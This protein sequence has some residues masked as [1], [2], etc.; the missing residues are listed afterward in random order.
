MTSSKGGSGF[1]DTELH[2]IPSFTIDSSVIL[3][4]DSIAS[5]F[6]LWC[7]HSS[8]CS[9]QLRD[10]FN[11]R[12]PSYK[13]VQMREGWSQKSIRF[14][15]V[16]H[17]TQQVSEAAQ[18]YSSHKLFVHSPRRNSLFDKLRGKSS[19]YVL[20]CLVESLS[21]EKS[22]VPVVNHWVPILK[23]MSPMQK[24]LEPTCVL[25]SQ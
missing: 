16:L 23:P 10:Q 22:E 4:V 24:F 9:K 8:V 21:C 6:L 19:D 14:K 5:I 2:K 12:W 11:F 1:R 25:P 18:T 15:P 17:A 13:G 20:N 7:F 3:T